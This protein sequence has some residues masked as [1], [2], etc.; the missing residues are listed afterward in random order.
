MGLERAFA[1]ERPSPSERNEERLRKRSRLLYR[2]KLRWY[3]L[4][5]EERLCKSLPPRRGTASDLE[6]EAVCRIR[7]NLAKKKKT[8]DL[9]KN[10]SSVQSEKLR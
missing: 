6:R 3:A 1:A 5:T 10:K 9:M 2:K 8:D 4:Y 7:K